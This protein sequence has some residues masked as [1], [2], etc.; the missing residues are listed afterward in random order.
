M[1]DLLIE[2]ELIKKGHKF[3][4]GIDEA[5]RGPLSGPVV[6]SC[7]ILKPFSEILG[8]NDSF[9]D[10]EII[11]N[12]YVHSDVARRRHCSKSGWCLSR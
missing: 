3:V 12:I 11:I 4:A 8:V 10:A 2:E 1:P 6:A 7:V 9:S 5:G